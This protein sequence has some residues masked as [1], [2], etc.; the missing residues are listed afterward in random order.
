[1]AITIDDVEALKRELE[2][3]PRNQPREVTKQEAIAMLASHLGAAKR[4]PIEPR[5]VDG[6]LVAHTRL[7]RALLR[8]RGSITIAGRCNDENGGG[9]RGRFGRPVP[10]FARGIVAPTLDLAGSEQCAG[11]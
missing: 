9:G 3:L 11:K 2:E 7:R 1:M 10:Q 5:F 8:W 4:H 6:T